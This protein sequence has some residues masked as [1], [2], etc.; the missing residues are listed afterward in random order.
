MKSH[1]APGNCRGRTQLGR[2]DARG[3][4]AGGGLSCRRET[5]GGPH[6]PGPPS[7]RRILESRFQAPA[8]AVLEQSLQGRRRRRGGT[9]SGAPTRRPHAG[10][11]A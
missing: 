7:S 6:A 8:P 10:R 2:F 9:L 5:P 1:G 4:A 3:S 11:L